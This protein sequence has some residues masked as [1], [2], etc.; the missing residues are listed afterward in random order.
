MES[1]GEMLIARC[2]KNSHREVSKIAM[3]YPQGRYIQFTSLA[4]MSFQFL[5][6]NMFQAINGTMPR[7]PEG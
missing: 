4:T 2:M 7:H 5:S 1:P 3:S 6:L